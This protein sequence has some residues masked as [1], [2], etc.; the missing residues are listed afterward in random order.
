VLPAP[1]GIPL[2]IGI[3]RKDLRMFLDQPGRRSGSGGAHDH[4]DPVSLGKFN[5]IIE[6]LKIELALP[7]FQGRPGEFTNADPFDPGL[8]QQIKIFIPQLP[9]SLFRI[10]G[11]A[12]LHA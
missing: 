11:D 6:T 5:A 7:R 2:F 1:E 4:P 10:V 12:D 3:Y 9:G 8:H